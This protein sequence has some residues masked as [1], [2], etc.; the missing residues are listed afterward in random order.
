MDTLFI[1]TRPKAV[2]QLALAMVFF[3]ICS[4]SPP[5][6]FGKLKGCG[7]ISSEKTS[8][9]Q[10]T[11]VVHG[12]YK[13]INIVTLPEEKLI[14]PVIFH[15]VYK[16]NQENISKKNIEKEISDLNR[17]FQKLN[18]DTTDTYPQYRHLIGNPNISFVLAD[19]TFYGSPD[20]G[21]KRVK[22][23]RRGDLYK[24]DPII[25]PDRYLNIYSGKIGSDG[26]T[27][28]KPWN[29]PATDA[30]FLYYEWVGGEYR[31][32]THETGHWLGLYHI[33][34]DGCSKENDGIADT[35]PQNDETGLGSGCNSESR[36]MKGNTCPGRTLPMFNNFMDYSDCRV[37]FTKGQAAEIRKN[38]FRYRPNIFRTLLVSRP[39]MFKKYE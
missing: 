22:R 39:V 28:T 38:L 17:D 4:C 31:L 26:F 6:R 14:I 7:F 30:I 5:S 29:N 27:Y 9:Q 37:M 24:S 2:Y 16:S 21:I 34:Q 1:Y 11:A 36:Y 25:A 20:K 15:V 19:T 13:A 35:E 18:A 3:C 8:N 32:L 10:D 23:T 12:S 33:F